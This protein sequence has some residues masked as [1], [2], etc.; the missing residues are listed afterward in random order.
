NI[1]VQAIALG[2]IKNIIDLRHIVKSS[3]KI[4]EYFPKDIE[5]WDNAYKEYLTKI[6]TVKEKNING[7]S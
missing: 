1:L 4:K 3:F 6:K 7:C 2:E 5:E